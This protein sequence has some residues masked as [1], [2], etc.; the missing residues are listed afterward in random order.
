VEWLADWP[1]A[2][3]RM[4]WFVWNAAAVLWVGWLV[5]MLVG[6]VHHLWWPVV[7]TIGYRAATVVGLLITLIAKFPGPAAYKFTTNSFDSNH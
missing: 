3:Q 1:P 2:G 6:A 4:I 7:P 5:M